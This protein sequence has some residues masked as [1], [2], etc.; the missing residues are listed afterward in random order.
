MQAWEG[1]VI[2]GDPA[3]AGHMLQATGTRNGVRSSVNFTTDKVV[4]NGSFG[5]VYAATCLETGETVSSP[6]RIGCACKGS[7]FR[8]HGVIT[9]TP[10]E[11]LAHGADSQQQHWS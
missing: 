8:V 6:C 4:G 2:R 11:Q 5:V 10:C 7:E 1:R 3:V 9:A